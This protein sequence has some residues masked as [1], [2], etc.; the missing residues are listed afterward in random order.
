M[1]IEPT[2]SAW[3]A[4]VIAIIRHPQARLDLPSSRSLI[5]W[6]GEDYYGL[7]ALRP[8]GRHTW[9]GVKNR[10]RR[11]F[12]TP[13]L[14]SNPPLTHRDT[15]FHPHSKI[16][17][18][19]YIHMVE[20]GGFEPP[21]AEPADL[22]SAPFGRSGTP[23]KTGSRIFCLTPPG[24][25]IKNGPNPAGIWAASLYRAALY[26]NPEQ[27]RLKN[28]AGRTNRTL[29]LLITSQLLYQLSYAG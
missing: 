27:I 9:C 8:S 13:G 16:Q 17:N 20:G 22:Q 19:L 12:R 5:W 4:E 3:K 21:K 23:P 25:S 6:R 24:L 7:P 18:L 2:S 29:D 1:G 26:R 15:S 10:S 11:F 28:G 14:G